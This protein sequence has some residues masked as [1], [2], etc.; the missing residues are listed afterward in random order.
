MKPLYKYINTM[1]SPEPMFRLHWFDWSMWLI[2]DNVQFS[3][4]LYT[5][6]TGGRLKQGRLQ[7]TR[8]TCEH[9]RSS[10]YD[11]IKQFLE[12]SPDDPDVQSKPP[13]GKCWREHTC[14]QRRS[15][16]RRTQRPLSW[17]IAYINV[18]LCSCTTKFPKI[19]TDHGFVA[20]QSYLC[21]TSTAAWG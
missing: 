5:P 7:E 20:G 21:T 13:I 10:S 11:H 15:L 12:T 18:H 8:G 1:L 2:R 3:I 16:G 6:R 4:V 9:V 17:I 14:S 19:I